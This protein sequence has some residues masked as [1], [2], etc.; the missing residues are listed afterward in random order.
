M[1]FKC[2]WLFWQKSQSIVFLDS[3][4]FPIAIRATG[5]ACEADPVSDVPIEKV[6]NQAF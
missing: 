1:I 6:N 2:L 3:L 5:H 4:Y